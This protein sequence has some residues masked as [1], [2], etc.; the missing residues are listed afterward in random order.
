MRRLTERE[1]ARPL[2]AHIVGKG[3][4]LGDA[5]LHQ[6]GEPR[7]ARL[8]LLPDTHPDAAANPFV[9]VAEEA[10]D[11]HQPEVP[12]PALEVTAKFSQN[13]RVNIASRT[14]AAQWRVAAGGGAVPARNVARRRQVPPWRRDLRWPDAAATLKFLAA[15]ARTARSAW[16]VRGPSVASAGRTVRAGGRGSSGRPYSGPAAG[17]PDRR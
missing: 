11:G 1:H 10:L 2:A 16:I 5:Q 13:R 7:A 4:V 15:S 14:Q 17:Y 6:G 3:F 9:Q 12:H 8:P